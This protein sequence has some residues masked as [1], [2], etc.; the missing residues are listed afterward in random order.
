MKYTKKI[1]YYISRII[2]YITPRE[3]KIRSRDLDPMTRY[4]DNEG[5]K[6][7]FN[8]FKEIFKK[9][10]LFTSVHEV[11]EYAIKEACSVDKNHEF[12]YLEFGV[13]KGTSTN[14]FSKFVKKL[15]AFDSFEGL[16]ED[17]VGHNLAKG[18]FNLNKKIPKL[19]SNI[20]PVVGFVQDTLEDFLAKHN[21][22]INFVHFDL[23]TYNSTKFTLE[24]IKPYLRKNAIIIFDQIYNYY[25][26]EQGEFKALNEVFNKDEYS[27]SAFNIRDKQAVIKINI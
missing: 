20:E 22:G 24:K 17:W 2:Y 14:F 1:F 5:A 8:Y 25:G 13:F 4:I 16:R 19:N 3:F 18:H 26:W 27:Y 15:F 9:S 21:P 11:R 12:F 23:D 7:S 6:S 10:V